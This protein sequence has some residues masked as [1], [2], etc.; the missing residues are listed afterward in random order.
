MH[1]K[2]PMLILSLLFYSST[3]AALKYA[4]TSEN[5]VFTYQLHQLSLSMTTKTARKILEE[6][7]FITT[8][9]HQSKKAQKTWQYS[10]GQVEIIFSKSIHSNNLNMI[11]VKQN[12]AKGKFFD[13][14]DWVEKI[15]ARWRA[16]KSESKALTNVCFTRHSARSK[17][18]QVVYAECFIKN[19]AS[20]SLGYHGI[21]NPTQIHQRLL[22]AE[23]IL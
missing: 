14:S 10:N 6:Q 7:G 1:K 2:I 23:P 17:N 22:R 5:E 4:Q 12:A 21:L 16:S 18:K 11:D 9:N 13:L 20:A 19:S 15:S 8:Y 3:V